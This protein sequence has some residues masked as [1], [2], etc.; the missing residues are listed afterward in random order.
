MVRGDGVSVA[1]GAW[2]AVGLG[3]GCVGYIGCW[4]RCWLNVT[5][6]VGPVLQDMVKVMLN[7]S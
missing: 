6:L 1:G 3:D 7:G 5:C 4:S 2:R